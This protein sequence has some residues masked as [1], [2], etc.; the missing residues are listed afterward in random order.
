[1]EQFEESRGFTHGELAQYGIRVEGGHIIIPTLGR[2]G[3]WYERLRCEAGCHPK[4]WSPPGTEPHLYNPL[5][6]GPNSDTVWIAEGEL[7]ALSLVVS[8]TP[9][10]GVLGAGNFRREWALLFEQADVV[11]AF[12]ADDAGDTSAA[13]VME[14]FQH[15][16]RFTPA[17]YKDMNEAFAADRQ[18]FE[19]VVKAW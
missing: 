6:L 13:K 1:M 2:S 4:Y 8:G 18:E 5:G 19:R 11:V 9:A 3:H 7:D 12:D 10:V 15:V 16:S 17:P 14:L